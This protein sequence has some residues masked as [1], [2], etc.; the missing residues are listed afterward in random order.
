MPEVA[1]NGNEHLPRLREIAEQAL[2]CTGGDGLAVVL[3]QQERLVCAISLGFAPPVGSPLAAGS[4]LS[5]ECLE[6]AMTVYCADTHHDWRVARTP[7]PAV[8]SVLLVPIMSAGKTIGL[9]VTFARRPD[10]FDARQFFLLNDLADDM[11]A[12]LRPSGPPASAAHESVTESSPA[13]DREAARA[14]M[15]ER[16]ASSEAVRDT[17][18][19]RG[20]EEELED[21]ALWDRQHWRKKVIVL[22]LAALLGASGVTAVTF[23]YQI[24]QWVRIVR[25]HIRWSHQPP[26]APAPEH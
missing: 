14:G 3:L 2:A 5:R 22:L 25:M 13:G 4:L 19:V 17:P 7:V 23:R 8:R 1:G 24:A 10:A 20:I 11:A 26:A 15:A 6:R 21:W 16:A 9:I 12:L 18:A